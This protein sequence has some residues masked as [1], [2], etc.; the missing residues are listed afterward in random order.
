M[1]PGLK[2][3]ASELQGGNFGGKGKDTEKNRR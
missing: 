2:P 3:S 1:Q